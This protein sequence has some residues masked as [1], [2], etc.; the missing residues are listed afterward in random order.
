M[1]SKE[2]GR[3][4]YNAEGRREQA[5]LT[6]ERILESARALFLARGYSGTSVADIAA[7]AGVSGPT[8]FSGFGSKPNLLKEAAETALVGDLDP[9]PMAQR[10]RMRHVHEGATAHD[11]LRRFADLVADW[12]PRACPMF[13]VVYAAA[14][15]DPEIARLARTFDD[16]RLAGATQIAGTALRRLGADPDDPAAQG[17]LAELRDTIWTMNSPQLYRLLVMQRGWPVQRYG[18]WIAR[19]LLAAVPSAD[20][21]R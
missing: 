12:A 18:A 15:A 3:R 13:L 11:V 5:R 2:Q 20:V 19:G 21:R 10:P 4:R 6:R 7:A 8:V 17:N 1:S 9:E 16:Q 14:D